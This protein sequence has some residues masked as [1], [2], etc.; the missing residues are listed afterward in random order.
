MVE[1]WTE[2]YT[3]QSVDA[4]FKGDCRWSSLLSIMQRAADKHVEALGIDREEMIRQGLG[5]MLI[6]LEAEMERIPR[7]METIHVETWSRG[8]K[9]VLWHRDYRIAGGN[10]ERIGAARSVWTLVDIH[11]RKILR[12]SMLPYEVPIG[13]ESVGEL[14][15]KAV[16]PEGIVLEEAYSAVVRYSGIDTNGHMNNA[17]YADLCLDALE[18]REHLA[19]KVTRFK[20]TY[21]REARMND[22]IAVKRSAESDGRIYVQGVSPEGTNYFEAELVIR[23]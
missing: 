3:I 12:P 17:R 13:Q 1:K 4:D 14:P 22:V 15:D 16:L 6:T 21:H 23:A 2:T 9:G 7:D 20:I 10:G 5:W 11:K 18:E 8:S 19:G